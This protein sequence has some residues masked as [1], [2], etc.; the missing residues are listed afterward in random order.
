[1]LDPS[2]S[3]FWK[4][5]LQS[6]L[7]ETPTLRTCWDAIAPEKRVAEHID[8]RLARHAVQSGV[9]TLWQAQQLMAGRSTG[10]KIDRYVL[11]ELLGQGGMG[12]VYLARDTRLNRHVALKILS[13]ERVNNPR[14]IARFHREAM[15]GAQLQ[16][17]NLVRIYDE[18]EANGRCY[19]V[20]EYIEGKTI[21][22]MITEHGP[23][24]PNVAA[25]L[26]RQ[27]ALGLEHAQR[28][29]LI[30]RDVNPFNILVTR[31][32]NAKLTDM[33]LAI[34]LADNDRVTR[35]GATV[36]TFDY[37]SPEQAR[38]SHSVDTRSDVYSLGCSLYHMLTAQVPFPS[39]SLPEKLFGHQASE[40]SPVRS[41]APRVPEGLAAVVVRAMRKSPDDRFASPLEMAAALEPF[42]DG[43]TV[44]SDDTPD[45]E[46]EVGPSKPRPPRT[47]ADAEAVAA[48]D[49][50]PGVPAAVDAPLPA[51]PPGSWPKEAA[52]FELPVDLGPEPPLSDRLASTR[53]KTKSKS[54]SRTGSES[55]DE[56]GPTAPPPWSP[57]ARPPWLVPAAVALATGLVAA[58]VL[59]AL[60][61]LGPDRRPSPA[62]Q[63]DVGNGRK[64]GPEARGAGTPDAA[65]GVNVKGGEVAVVAADGTTTV[66]P[67]LRTAVRSA[68]GSRGH[69]LLLNREPLTVPAGEP[70]LAPSG[71]LVI[72]AGKGLRPEI[73][74]EVKGGKPFLTTRGESTIRM[75]GV[76]LVARMVDPGPAPSALIEAGGDVVLD[77]CDFRAEGDVKGSIALVQEGRELT[78]T[79]C[80][81]VNFERA[82]DAAS[83]N[84]SVTTLRQCMIVQTHPPDHAKH[85]GGGEASPAGGAPPPAG[86]VRLRALGGGAARAG[87]RLVLENCTVKAPVFLELDGF[88]PL[89][90]LSVEVRGCAAASDALLTWGAGVL[91]D[92]PPAPPSTESL[93]WKGQGDQYEVGGKTWVRLAGREG[94]PEAPWAD[95]P[96]DLEGWSKRVGPEGDPIDK[97]V[98]FA[99]D[100]SAL[101]E[102]PTPGDFAPAEAFASSAGADP[103][104]VGPGAAQASSSATP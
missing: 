81:F 5:V 90:P 8:R 32:G 19:L 45:L 21:G 70:L 11:L 100:P 35:D 83:L 93:S 41:L 63:S 36:G 10:F 80:L 3:R 92:G 104:F 4:A 43:I 71:L 51:S 9:L 12:R 18:G 31:D 33:G 89:L 62:S 17:E 53:S 23:L 40:P 44:T 95:A 97:P 30:H 101:P 88:T 2:A 76:T 58:A 72:R 64:G 102:R 82:I 54:R 48:A 65:D 38:H 56:A 74:V 68:V 37:V 6:G 94:K 86:S 85:E 46:A 84:G 103:A 22:Q 57:G 16:H 77:R 78:A 26:S 39:A 34:D 15:V 29:G 99:T 75:E 96:A 25:R 67:D 55:G 49:P 24:P 60:T 27:V 50:G 91:H 7:V 69:V 87:R 28:K 1:M 59:L 47:E 14:A 13:P 42:A 52:G 20:M 79:G 98:K 73:R 66:E 61:Y